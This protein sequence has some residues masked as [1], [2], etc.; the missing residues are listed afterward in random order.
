MPRFFAV[1]VALLMLACAPASLA[2]DERMLRHQQ[3]VLAE[4]AWKG[5]GQPVDRVSGYV[6]ADI[7]AER[8]YLQFV[9]IRE[10]YWQS[11]TEAEKARAVEIGQ[12]MMDEYGDAASRKR[13]TLHLRKARHS[14]IGSRPRKDAEVLVPGPNG[15]SIYIRGDQFYAEKFWQPEKYHQWVDETWGET[16]EGKVDVG[17]L[18][19]VP[20]QE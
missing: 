11:L 19:Q 13:L 3:A 17:S 8:G 15:Q 20:G 14:M 6:W 2:Q 16:P 10:R 1:S 18:E 9:A 5:L 4:M 12:P 7:A